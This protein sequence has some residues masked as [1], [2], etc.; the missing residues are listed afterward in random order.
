[1]A[2]RRG[3]LAALAVMAVAHAAVAQNDTVQAASTASGGSYPHHRHC[4]DG[5]TWCDGRC[6]LK[7]FFLDKP[8]HCGKVRGRA[9]MLRQLSSRH[10]TCRFKPRV[11]DCWPPRPG[12]VRWGPPPTV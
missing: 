10:R 9:C 2:L 5:Q 8:G 6:V 4:R 3:V 1:M 7:A 12:P 11:R